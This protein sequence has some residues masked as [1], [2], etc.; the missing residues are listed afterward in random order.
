M[1]IDHQFIHFYLISNHT[2]LNLPAFFTLHYYN[3]YF[4]YSSILLLFDLL[5]LKWSV[6][7]IILASTD[8]S[9][10]LKIKFEAKLK[11]YSFWHFWQTPCKS[12]I[13][14]LFVI[15]KKKQSKRRMMRKMMI[16][17][18]KKIRFDNL[19]IHLHTFAQSS[20]LFT[21]SWL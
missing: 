2:W 14:F 9:L 19:K 8:Q 13:D 6:T 18:P 4:D 1:T 7:S 3:Y 16:I 5:K 10:C 12:I 17:F 21:L 15:N 20:N 11:S